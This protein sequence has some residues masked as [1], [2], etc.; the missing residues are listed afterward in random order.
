M[1][2][3][4]V[5]ARGTVLDGRGGLHLGDYVA[6]SPEALLLSA[7]HEPD[8]PDFLGD[9]R[10]TS[11]AS[12]AWIASRAIVLPGSRIGEG[13][14]VGAGSVVHGDVPPWT[15]VAGSPAI[16]IRQRSPTAQQRLA[17]YRRWWH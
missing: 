6:V 4:C 11:I 15:I 14:I 13:A 7:G 8:S 5:I 16:A 10:T 12:R 1:G 3:G 17:P 9:L 2:A